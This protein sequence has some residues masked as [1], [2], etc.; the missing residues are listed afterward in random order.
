[1]RRKLISVLFLTVACVLV[2]VDSPAS[3]WTPMRDFDNF[4]CPQFCPIGADLC[5]VY[6]PPICAPYPCQE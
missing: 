4:E 3:A 2:G 1:M 6:L 5:C